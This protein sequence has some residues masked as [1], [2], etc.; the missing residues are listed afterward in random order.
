MSIDEKI[1]VLDHLNIW[2]VINECLKELTEQIIIMNQDQMYEQG[3][4]NV[5]TGE[6]QQYTDAYKKRKMKTARYNKTDFVTLKSD[7]GYYAGMELEIYP[8]ESEFLFGIISSDW[9][10]LFMKSNKRWTPP[11][12]FALA[13]G[14]TKE[15]IRMLIN[16]IHPIA[17]RKI[18]EQLQ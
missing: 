3:V 10:H 11:D 17:V 13:F 7:G 1:S 8:P 14:L 4:M 15:N 5:K 12:R 9:K 18:K 2:V 6:Q 16:L